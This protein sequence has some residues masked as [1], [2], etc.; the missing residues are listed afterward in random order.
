MWRP[1]FGCAIAIAVPAFLFGLISALI[2]T[3]GS[4]FVSLGIGAMAAGMA[5]VGVLVMFA[6]DSAR[7][8]SNQNG[9]RSLLL[10]RDNIPDEL[11]LSKFEMS[12][13]ELALHLRGRLAE[14]FQVQPNNIHPDDD[15]AF[16][17]FEHFMPGIY[18]FLMNG[19]DQRE[20]PPGTIDGFP[21]TELKTVASLVAEAK[22]LRK[23][24]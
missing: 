23:P 20:L 3:R 16:L 21:K 10:A 15:L 22:R 19:L 1:M 11:F 4:L 18:F 9:V 14:F 6:V 24:E 12:D 13:R 17:C 7:W 8:S 2:S 5:F